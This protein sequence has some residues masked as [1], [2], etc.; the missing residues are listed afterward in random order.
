M[1]PPAPGCNGGACIVLA[2]RRSA[3]SMTHGWAKLAQHSTACQHTPSISPRLRCMSISSPCFVPGHKTEWFRRHCTIPCAHTIP[4]ALHEQLQAPLPL[5]LVLRVEGV[6]H[7]W[8]R[9][10]RGEE[11]SG[12]QGAG[13]GA[14]CLDDLPAELLHAPDVVGRPL[15]PCAA[16]CMWKPVCPFCC[17]LPT[18]PCLTNRPHQQVIGHAL[19]PALAPHQQLPRHAIVPSFEVLYAALRRARELRASRRGR[20]AG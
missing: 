8:G 19:R 14:A 1:L 6:P 17:K 2:G 3:C 16:S 5:P 12:G 10:S 13:Y 11:E 18:S 4:P 20:G 9:N 15:S 7:L